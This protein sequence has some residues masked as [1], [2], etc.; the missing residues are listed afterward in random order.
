[1]VT[2]GTAT[3]IRWFKNSQQ[4]T[5]AAN[6]RLS[7]STVSNPGLTI[8]NV[9]TS[10]GGTYEC[11]ATDGTSTV[12]ANPISLSPVPPLQIAAPQTIYNPT[13]GDTIVLNCV[14]TSGTATTIRWYKNSQEIVMFANPRYSGGNQNTPPLTITNVQTSDAGSYECEGTDSFTTVRTSA[15]IVNVRGMS[16]SH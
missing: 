4:I 14:V 9:Q 16:L 10:D 12:R 2:Q 6:Q 3:Q 8:S 1:M 13:T 7:G 5:L 11:E 15:I